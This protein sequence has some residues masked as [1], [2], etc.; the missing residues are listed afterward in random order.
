MFAGQGY[1]SATLA[2]QAITVIAT[3][4]G[5]LDI[6]QTFVVAKVVELVM[7]IPGV[8]N[9]HLSGSPTDLTA[10]YAQKFMPGTLAFVGA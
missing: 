6:G 5:G 4:I 3:Y 2:G 9:F 10:T 8:V 7:D 1:A